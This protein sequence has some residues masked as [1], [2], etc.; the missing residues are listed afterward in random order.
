MGNRGITILLPT[1]DEAKALRNV[2]NRIPFDE[3]SADGWK[4]RIVVVD[5]GSTDGTI[6]LAKELN[7][8]I[9]QQHGG[10]GK[11]RG[12]RFLFIEILQTICPVIPYNY[13]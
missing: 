3:I 7:C 12:L 5:G 13:K 10:A 8:Q 9:I 4:I 1:L 11:G 6:E 2:V